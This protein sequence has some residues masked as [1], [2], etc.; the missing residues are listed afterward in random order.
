MSRRRSSR[1]PTIAWPMA[2]RVPGAEM[3]SPEFLAVRELIAG[4]SYM[5]ATDAVEG[6][7]LMDA[8][9]GALRPAEGV[10]VAEVD[11]V[12]RSALWVRPVGASSDRVVLYLHGGAYRIGSHV[13]YR[14]A[15]SHFAV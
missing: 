14:S 3:A 11:V 2:L 15:V 13:A 10:D 5:D 4:T 9:L 12:G 7:A 6:R 1:C 8:A